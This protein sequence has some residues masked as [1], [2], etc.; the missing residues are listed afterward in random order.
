MTPDLTAGY[1]TDRITHLDTH[2]EYMRRCDRSETTMRRRIETLA[3]LADYLDSDPANASFDQLYAWQGTLANPGLVRWRTALIRPYYGHLRALGFRHDDP[4][5]LLPIPRR[6]RT[7]RRAMPDD[8]LF[9]VVGTAPMPV[10]AF[11]L[12]AGWCGLRAKEIAGLHREHFVRDRAGHMEVI[13]TGKGGDQRQVPVPEWVHETIADQLPDRG[14]L[15]VKTNRGGARAGDQMAG[16]N[17][18]DRVAD[19]LEAQGIT[20]RLHSL[21]HRVATAVLH[22]THDV[23]LV[24]ELLGHRNLSALHVYTHVAPGQVA[25][26]VDRLPRPDGAPTTS[27]QADGHLIVDATD[28]QSIE[29]VTY[30]IQTLTK[31]ERQTAAGW[32]VLPADIARAVVL[33]ANR[34]IV[35]PQRC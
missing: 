2:L 15:F 28:E 6:R 27:V 34:R 20:D 33:A 31:V 35:E 13:V 18:T 24:Q 29:G 8:D 11:L 22:D 26:A 3:A 1:R 7:T 32:S 19:Y 25:R 17:V 16:H 21:R 23:R 9:R 12:L 10:L 4:S 30:R 14:P 5:R